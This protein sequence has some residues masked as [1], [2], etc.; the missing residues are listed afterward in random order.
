[1]RLIRKKRRLWRF[2]TTDPMARKDFSQF[3]AYKKGPEGGTDCS[4]K[5]QEELREEA[6]QRLQKEPQGILV[7]HEEENKQQGDSGA[8]ER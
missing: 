6:C 3:E 5:C 8:L 4:E 7:L 2:Y 1:M